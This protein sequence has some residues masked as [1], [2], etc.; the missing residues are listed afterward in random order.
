M[1]RRIRLMLSAGSKV[2]FAPPISVR[3]QPGLTT[4]QV[5]PSGARSIARLRM[6]MFTGL[7]SADSKASFKLSPISTTRVGK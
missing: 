1:R 5:M 7:G 2:A 4:T 6:I 3:T